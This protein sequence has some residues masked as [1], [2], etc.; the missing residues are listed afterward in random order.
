MRI[1]IVAPSRGLTRDVA[2][3]ALALAAQDF[4]QARLIIHPQCFLRDGHFAGPDAV[5]AAAFVDMANDPEIDALWFARGGYGA[6]RLLDAVM[7]ALGPAA[8]RKTYL[9][10]SDGGFLLAALYQAGIGRPVHGPMVA[11]LARDG[12]ESAFARALSFLVGGEQAG[13]QAQP[14]LRI[15][16]NLTILATLIGSRWLPELMGH[17][18]MIEEVAEPMYRIDRMLFQL[19]SAPALRGL[20][21]IS[22]GRVTDVVANDPPWGEPVEQMI[23]RCCAT[24]GVAYLGRCDIGH[25]ADNMIVPFG[26]LSR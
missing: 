10:Y 25:D 18:L 13:L 4:P 6:N 5:R 14:E 1:G 24:L 26:G 9:G 12:G 3:R 19:A 21:G 15:A 8:R 11:D 16:M 22:L 7:P 23:E 17:V 2:D 20:A